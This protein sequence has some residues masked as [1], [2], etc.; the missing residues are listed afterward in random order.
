MEK[1]RPRQVLIWEAALFSFCP[2]TVVLRNFCVKLRASLNGGRRF[3]SAE[4]FDFLDLTGTYLVSKL[5]TSLFPALFPDE[6][7]LPESPQKHC[8]DDSNILK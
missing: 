7:Y 8:Q 6:N 3:A 5:E 2:E 4:D 1:P